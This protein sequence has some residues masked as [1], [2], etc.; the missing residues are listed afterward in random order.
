MEGAVITLE[1]PASLKSRLSQGHP[2]V[3]RNQLQVLPE[4]PSGV[5]VR[6]RCGGFS[7]IG[8]WDAHSA[9]AV[10]LFSQRAVPDQEWVAKRVA[11][12]WSL[13][14]PVRAGATSAYR[15]IFGESDGLPGIVVDLYDRFAV[16]LTYVESVGVL[17]PWVAE[18]LHAHVDLHGIL[19]RP[20]DGAKLR[21]LWGRLPPPDLVVEEH[22]I[23]YHANLEAG[24]K[25][26]LYFDQR[27]NRLA[28]GPWCQGKTVLDCFC[29]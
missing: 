20:A 8:L 11:E 12:A 28:L 6:V 26:G 3:Y 27:E 1:L 23:L 2:W 14:A 16:I 17:V 15:W 10:R 21:S 13:R 22:G 24:Q 5:W 7:V 19:L 4:L 9:I 18:A 25:S 29:C